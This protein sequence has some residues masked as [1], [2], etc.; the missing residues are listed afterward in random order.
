LTEIPEHLLARSK[1][2]RDGGAAGGG[3]ATPAAAPAADAGGS[4]AVE[5]SA[6]AATAVADSTPAVP[7]PVAPWVEAAQKRKKIPFWAVPVLAFLPIWAVLYALTLDPPTAT[8]PG[9]LQL[10]AEVYAKCAGCH[11]A[12]GGGNGAIP[13]LTGE[14]AVTKLF[15]KPADMITWIAL[16]T[17]GY[18]SAGIANYAEGY[19]VGGSGAQMPAWLTS[20]S[21]EEIMSVTLHEREAF[22]GETFDIAMWEDGFEETLTKLLP[23]DKV[24]E[25]M[26]VLEEWKANPPA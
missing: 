24:E 21:A 18:Q 25:F 26:M 22:N 16:G 17:A 12:G 9:P 4:A 7:D 20:L 15:P 6:P 2:R 5:K 23:A 13:A 3:D 19:P 8:E 10:G 1:A 14:S 11:G